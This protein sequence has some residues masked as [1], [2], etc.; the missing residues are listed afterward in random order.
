MGLPVSVA[1]T[2]SESIV[3][4]VQPDTVMEWEPT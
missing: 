1:L 2:G 4:L 3:L